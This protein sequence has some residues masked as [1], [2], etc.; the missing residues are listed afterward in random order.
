MRSLYFMSNSLLDLHAVIIAFNPDQKNISTLIECLSAAVGHVWVVD[1]NSDCSFMQPSLLEK[2]NV[3]LVRLDNNVGI[4]KAQNIGIEHAIGS[5]AKHIIFFDHDSKVTQDLILNLYQQYSIL[6]STHGDVAAVGPIFVDPRYSFIYPIIKLNSLGVRKRIVPTPGAE[7][8]E[9]SFIISSGTLTSVDV[10]EDVGLFRED[11]FI[12]Y[13]DTEW[14]FRVLDK[15]YKLF[16]VP[17]AVMEHT[18]GDA[19]I[20]FLMWKLPVHSAFRRYYRMRNMFYLF[21][22]PYVPLLLKIREFITNNIHQLLIVLSSNNKTTYLKCWMK[23][24]VDGIKILLGKH[25]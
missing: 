9:A 22:L 1:N 4:A 15:G 8:F 18:I 20:K 25:L 23:S 14:C 12:D 11:F 6:N 2:S 7:P 13:V 5:N 24:F 21:R 19:N 17:S 16:V 3:T 10:L